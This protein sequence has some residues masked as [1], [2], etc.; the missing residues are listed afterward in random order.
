MTRPAGVPRQ[1][2]SV[3]ELIQRVRAE[4]S[5]PSPVAGAGRWDRVAP[6]KPRPRADALTW[7][8]AAAAVLV[9]VLSVFAL[10]SFVA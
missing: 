4:N 10:V 5:P 9:T 1:Q 8:L 6:G 7:W 2:I 3:Q